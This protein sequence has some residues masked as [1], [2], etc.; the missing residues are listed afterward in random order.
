MSL[1]AIGFKQDVSI[2]IYE[3]NLQFIRKSFA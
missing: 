2:I 3:K 1:T